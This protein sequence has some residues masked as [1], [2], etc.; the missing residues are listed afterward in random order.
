MFA[1]RLRTAQ[2]F[3]TAGNKNLLVHSNLQSKMYERL[4]L[5]QKLL[6][7]SILMIFSNFI[8]MC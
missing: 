3:S 1:A 2:Q 7:N 5:V 8:K 6:F 4:Q